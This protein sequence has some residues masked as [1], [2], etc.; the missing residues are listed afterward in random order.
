VGLL[1]DRM[2]SRKIGGREMETKSKACLSARWRK[3]LLCDVVE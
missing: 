3:L 1:A 2:I